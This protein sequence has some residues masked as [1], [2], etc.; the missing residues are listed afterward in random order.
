MNFIPLIC[1][2]CKSLFN[3]PLKVYNRQ[4]KNGKKDFYCSRQCYRTSENE[5][6]VTCRRILRD[7]RKSARRKHLAIDIDLNFLLFLW[8]KQRGKCSYTSKEMILNKNKKSSPESASLDRIN[9]GKGYVKD[10]VEFICLFVNLG[11]KEFHKEEIVNF[12]ANIRR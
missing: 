11:K 9:S 3:K 10:N 7:S 4:V 8:E 1:C 5:L 6:I 2:H 12:L